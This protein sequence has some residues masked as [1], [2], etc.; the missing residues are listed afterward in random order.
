[1]QAIPGI[2][3]LVAVV[4]VVQAYNRSF[5]TAVF[6]LIL[7]TRIGVCAALSLVVPTLVVVL[8]IVVLCT[9]AAKFPADEFANEVNRMKY[10]IKITF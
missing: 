10:Y 8:H 2:R 3:W 1:M 4:C 6:I 7:I 9:A 5:V